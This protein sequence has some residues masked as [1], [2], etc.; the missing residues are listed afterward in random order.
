MVET[1]YA[2]TPDLNRLPPPSLSPLAKRYWWVLNKDW[3]I[4]GYTVP[5]GFVSQLE[6]TPRV[7][8]IRTIFRG[9]GRQAALLHDWLYSTC[10]TSRKEADEYFYKL[11]LEENVPSVV[12]YLT[13]LAVRLSGKKKYQQYKKHNFRHRVYLRIANG[14]GNAPIFHER[15]M[16]Q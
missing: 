4:Y 16:R 12:A 8:F 13:Y 14:D 6:P 1:T 10:L 11:M 2:R 7:P 3:S 5:K 15:N 9:R